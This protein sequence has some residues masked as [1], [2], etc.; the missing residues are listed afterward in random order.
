MNIGDK[1]FC[2]Y[3]S[4]ED[5]QIITKG[6]TYT[7]VEKIDNTSYYFRNNYGRLTEISIGNLNIYFYT[8]EELRSVK[9]NSI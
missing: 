1:L 4:G 5:E 2:K 3:S 9:L 8:K 7:I 6:K